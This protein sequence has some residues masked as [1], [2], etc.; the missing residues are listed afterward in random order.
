MALSASRATRSRETTAR[1][2]P[3]KNGV[4]AFAGAIAVND[5]GKAAPGRTAVGLVAM[6]IFT[7][8]ADNQ[9]GSLD[10]EPTPI[11]AGCFGFNNSIADPV[12]DIHVGKEVV[13]EDDE[14]IAATD[15]GGTRSPAGICFE[16]EEGRVWVV[17]GI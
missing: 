5:A 3:L 10:D 17:I 4:I 13:I 15:G 9:T 1:N 14:T 6:G 16:L 11:E 2:L 12:G 7:K 8:D